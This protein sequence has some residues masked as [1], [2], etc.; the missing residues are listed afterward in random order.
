M[1]QIVV[2][3]FC[4]LA[5]WSG[6]FLAAV[7]KAY[8]GYGLPHLFA[9]SLRLREFLRERVV[10]MAPP[11]NGLAELPRYHLY[12]CITKRL[13]H[14]RARIFRRHK[15]GER[16]LQLRTTEGLYHHPLQYRAVRFTQQRAC[17]S[18]RIN[19][20]VP[21]AETQQGRKDVR[22][23]SFVSVKFG[24]LEERMHAVHLR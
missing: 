21:E 4:S 9:S 14:T 13:D 10:V 3:C 23:P 15:G 8:D 1:K 6:E 16:R 2:D 18:Y 24:A 5:W 22:F 7:P 20:S 11:R 12:C 19:P 17:V